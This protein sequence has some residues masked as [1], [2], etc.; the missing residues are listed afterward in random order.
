MA[1]ALSDILYDLLVLAVK[2]GLDM[3]EEY[4]KVLGELMERIKSGEFDTK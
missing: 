1:N 3:E 2:Y 4:A